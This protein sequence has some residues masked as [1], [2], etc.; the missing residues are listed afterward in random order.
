MLK[1]HHGKIVIG[2]H[3]ET[4]TGSVIYEGGRIPGQAGSFPGRTVPGQT[5]TTY[6][7]GTSP[8]QT[9]PGTKSR[10]LK[11]TCFKCLKVI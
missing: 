9:Y 3:G 4:G 5:E 8:G 6:S 10:E 1:I 11:E 2:R 7:G